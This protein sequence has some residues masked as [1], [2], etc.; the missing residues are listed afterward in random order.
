MKQ[1]GQIEESPALIDRAVALLEELEGV[2]QQAYKDSVGLWTIGVGHL[3]TAGERHSGQVVVDGR[4]MP[5]RTGLSLADVS[6]LLRQDVRPYVALVRETVAVPLT[7]GQRVALVCFAFNVGAG[8]YRRSTLLR[9]L[10]LGQL[11]AVPGQLRRW[12]HA[13]GKVVAGLANRRERE[14]CVWEQ[15]T[16]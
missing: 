8:A 11:E 5:W 13:G 1:A 12:V 4:P 6:A 9:K 3:L 7:D 16:A 2:R 15:G 14:V 10:N